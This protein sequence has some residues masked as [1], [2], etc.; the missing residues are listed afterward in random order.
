MKSD[1]LA[2]SVLYAGESA[3]DRVWLPHPITRSLRDIEDL[4]TEGSVIV[5]YESIPR[6]WTTFGL[7]Y[8]HLI[9]KRQGQ[10]G[11]TWHMDEIFIPPGRLPLARS[12][13]A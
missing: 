7:D 4:L 9:R 11:D 5:S 6:W 12:P 1:L 2:I 13:L 10:R 8:A 3:A